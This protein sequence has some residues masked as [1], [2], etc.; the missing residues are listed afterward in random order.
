MSFWRPGTAKPNESGIIS[1]PVTSKDENNGKVLETK[2]G[3]ATLS[4]SVMTMKFMKRKATP[5]MNEMNSNK[6]SKA[7]E[8]IQDSSEL[9][10]HQKLIEELSQNYD[11]SNNSYQ[12]IQHS[13]SSYK[14]DQ[15]FPGRRSYGGFNKAVELNYQ[16]YL[17]E[18]RYNKLTKSKA[19]SIDENEVIERCEQ[20]ISLPRGPNQGVR[21]DNR[22]SHEY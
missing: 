7:H 12:E 19:W 5:D 11:L 3:K 2:E 18:K 13:N 22:K 1:S 16:N 20:L 14:C 9:I 10:I 15:T 8:T 17:D 6:K 21:M 4:K